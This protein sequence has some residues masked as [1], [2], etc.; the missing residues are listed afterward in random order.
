MK[1]GIFSTVSASLVAERAHQISWPSQRLFHA[2]AL[3]TS[4][5]ATEKLLRNDTFQATVHPYP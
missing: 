3:T 2:S 5:R 4:R 1:S